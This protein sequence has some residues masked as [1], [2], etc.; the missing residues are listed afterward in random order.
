MT[1]MTE[2]EG[3]GAKIRKGL[4]RRREVLSYRVERDIVIP[5]GTILRDAGS[6]DRFSAPIGFGVTAGQFSI[7]VEPGDKVSDYFKTVIAS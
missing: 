7:R 3:K 4:S 5:A 6:D 2:K 1:E